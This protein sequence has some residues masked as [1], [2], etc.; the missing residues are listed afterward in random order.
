MKNKD[1]PAMAKGNDQERQGE[2]E[3]TMAS[4]NNCKGKSKS[5]CTIILCCKRREVHTK[6]EI[7]SQSKQEASN[8]QSGLKV[9]RALP[10]FNPGL[11]FLE[12]V[13]KATRC[14]KY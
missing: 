5:K 8:W 11:K 2:S 10:I 9:G 3:L 6:T 14:H 12:E 4:E 13:D 7:M 1:A